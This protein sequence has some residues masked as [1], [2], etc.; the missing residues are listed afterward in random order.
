MDPLIRENTLVLTKSYTDAADGSLVVILPDGETKPL[1]RF[2]RYDKDRALF[3]SE[4]SLDNKIYTVDDATII[5][6][7]I[8][9]I[10]I[11]NTL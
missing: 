11:F 6:D 1:V 4:N 5:G 7:V 10:N 2:L 8:A 9:S 3:I